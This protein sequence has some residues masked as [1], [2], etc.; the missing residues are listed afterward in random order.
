MYVWECTNVEDTGVENLLQEPLVGPVKYI[1][2]CDTAFN[3]VTCIL[4][5]QTCKQMHYT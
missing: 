1:S 5:P 3:L 2:K 4:T